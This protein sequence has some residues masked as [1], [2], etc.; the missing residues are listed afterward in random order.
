MRSTFSTTLHPYRQTGCLI[1]L[2]GAL[3]CSESDPEIIGGSD[4]ER[5]DISQLQ[6]LAD[7][8]DA[9]AQ[10]AL[11][12]IHT[13]GDDVPQDLTTALAWMRRA[14]EQ[15]HLQAQYELGRFHTR[16]GP[17]QDFAEA[18]KWLRR[19][20]E[21]GYPRAQLTL[22]MLYA[23]GQGVEQDMAEAYAWVSLAEQAGDEMAG[24]T[25]QQIADVLRDDELARAVTLAYDYQRRYRTSVKQ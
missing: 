24:A 20:A 22:G 8:G 6:P 1:V 18:V 2:L 19:S 9:D 14:A 13:A 17:R 15:N 23:A 21:R 7:A 16:Q 11:G 3:S 12:M 10:F 4:L 25:I 5:L